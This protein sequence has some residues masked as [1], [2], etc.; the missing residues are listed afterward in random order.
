MEG[1]GDRGR[2]REEREGAERQGGS[3]ADLFGASYPLL[4]WR[5]RGRLPP[6]AMLASPKKKR[7]RT[8][9]ERSES[10]R[11]EKKET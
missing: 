9:E 11:L 8:R 10:K 3:K 2:N 5:T 1:V 6:Q 7:R 4:R